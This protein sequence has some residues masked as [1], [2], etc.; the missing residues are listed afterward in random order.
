[1]LSNPGTRFLF[2]DSKKT[3]LCYFIH[4]SVS[5]ALPY[6]VQIYINELS[7]HFDKVKVLCN[8]SKIKDKKY[9]LSS[10]VEILHKPNKGYDFGMFYRFVIDKNLDEYAQIAVVNDSNILLNKLDSVFNWAKSNNSDFWGIID[11]HE[12]PWF[13]THDNSYHIQS[14]FLVFNKRAIEKLASFF[15]LLDIKEI[16]EENK[17]KQLRRL[18]IDKWEIGISQYLISQNLNYASFI[19]NESVRKK[20]ATEGLNLTHTFYHELAEEGYP[21]LKKKVTQSKRK[22]FK[23]KDIRWKN[24]ISEFAHRDW[25]TFKIISE[26]A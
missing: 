11:S 15:E 6:H 19:N 8:N 7:R 12:K 22:W 17:P 2:M 14:H 9:L 16:M 18:V 3:S 10:N 21:L 1:M 23:S 13:S 5:N 26:C 25:D 20:F 24:T 4:Y